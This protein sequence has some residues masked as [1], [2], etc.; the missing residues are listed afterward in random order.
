MIPYMA[1]SKGL[2]ESKISITNQWVQGERQ[3]E[4]KYMPEIWE[5]TEEEKEEE[6]ERWDIWWQKNWKVPP[7]SLFPPPRLA[8]AY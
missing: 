7:T 8:P 2:K 5:F 4:S 1:G 3:Y 6:Q